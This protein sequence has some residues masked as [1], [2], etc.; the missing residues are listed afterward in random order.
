MDDHTRA[1]S[2]GP[3]QQQVGSS[4]RD[5][6]IASDLDVALA[7]SN[8]A[9]ARARAELMAWLEPNSSDAGLIDDARLLVSELVTNCVRHARTTSRR[10]LR[11]TASLWP[12]ALRLAVHDDGT[13]GTVAR[14]APGSDGD[15][16]FGLDLVARISS[17][18]G[19]ERDAHGTTVWL[20]LDTDGVSAA[21][22]RFERIGEA[23]P[24]ES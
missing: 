1:P 11:V 21:G 23:E 24:G 22:S 3:A 6:A 2:S 9:P 18:W 17:A 16:G 10:P 4:T 15:G 7:A 14:R 13:D 19:V 8:D 12:A 5:G 20:Q